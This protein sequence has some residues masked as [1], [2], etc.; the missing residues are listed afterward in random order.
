MS[1]YYLP[2]LIS[3]SGDNE[4][5]RS[6]LINVPELYGRQRCP[7][8]VYRPYQDDKHDYAKCR[9]FHKCGLQSLLFAAVISPIEDVAESFEDMTI[10]ATTRQV[11]DAQTIRYLQ[12]YSIDRQGFNCNKH[13]Y[14]YSARIL[15]KISVANCSQS[16][17]CGRNGSG[18]FLLDIIARGLFNISDLQ[19]RTYILDNWPLLYGGSIAIGYDY[20]VTHTNAVVL[21][22]NS[23][24]VR[25]R[26]VLLNRLGV[27]TGFCLASN[28]SSDPSKWT[29]TSSFSGDDAGNYVPVI[30]YNDALTQYLVNLGMLNS[31]FD[32]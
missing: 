23:A 5:S 20:T 2:R 11:K 15:D 24:G 18:F 16:K 6:Q 9:D 21:F 32:L 8:C 31:A 4:F 29:F 10:T 27:H 7:W 22:M 25:Y 13:C 12:L 3:Y 19:I 14:H 17:G 28:G 1:V 30:Y 26:I